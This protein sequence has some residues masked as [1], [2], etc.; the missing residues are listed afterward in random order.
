M[1]RKAM[2]NATLEE[3]VQTIYERLISIAEI[4]RKGF[5]GYERFLIFDN[6]IR[7]DRFVCD[8]P[9][10]PIQID[11][12]MSSI[13]NLN[14]RWCVG[15]YILK[16]ND[17][18]Q[19]PNTHTEEKLKKIVKDII[20]FSDH[21]IAVKTVLFSGLTGEPLVTRDLTLMAMSLIRKAGIRV[22]LY[23]NGLLMGPETWAML[24]NIQ[25][26]HVSLDGGPKS[27]KGI[28]R[29]TIFSHEADP[30]NTVLKNISGISSMKK[31][32]GSTTEI[33]IGYTITKDNF[34]EIDEVIS[35]LLKMEV[36]S[37]CLKHDITGS[38][39]LGEKLYG[40]LMLKYIMRC[41]R[42]YDNASGFRV[43]VM[44]ESKPVDAKASWCCRDGCY[45]RWFFCTIGSN[46]IMYPCDYQTASGCPEFG[47]VSKESLKNVWD[48]KQQN[49]DLIVTK[50]DNFKNICPPFAERVNRFLH[51]IVQ[52]KRL[53]S[54]Q[55]VMA[56]INRIRNT[57]I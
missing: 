31:S 5:L 7:L 22:G 32:I 39:F 8:L 53:Y 19:L 18:N 48:K 56:A 9:F 34:T 41:Q 26:V 36:N 43:F 46:G 40:K 54:S 10:P 47:D 13:C 38:D 23:T 42:K 33:N 11:L 44:H 37:I 14:C 35:T 52:M 16:Q 1:Q 55:A 15:R 57:F 12:Q 3:V 21:E 45:Y 50:N 29:P 2:N 27:W 28:K 17:M 20:D 24:L 30:Y 51:E 6:A 49:W 4:S 25:S